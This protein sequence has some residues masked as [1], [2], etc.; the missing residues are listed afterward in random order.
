MMTIRGTCDLS[1]LT[2]R[3]LVLNF[4]AQVTTNQKPESDLCRGTSPD[5]GNEL[6]ARKSTAVFTLLLVLCLRLGNINR[7]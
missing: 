5:A 6:N 1:S 4:R 3:W 7:S 2:G